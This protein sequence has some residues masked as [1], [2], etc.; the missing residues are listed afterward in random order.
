[1]VDDGVGP[2]DAWA[3]PTRGRLRHLQRLGL[4]ARTGKVM[5]VAQSLNDIVETYGANDTML[6]NCAVDT[7]FSALDPLT[8]DKVSR[9]TGTVSEDPLASETFGGLEGPGR[10]RA[11][12]AVEILQSSSRGCHGASD[13]PS[14]S[15]AIGDSLKS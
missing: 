3:A 7:A 8:P 4:A 1:M 13:L 5:F 15:G 6:D 11:I 10:W 2:T 9:L 14:Y 12:A